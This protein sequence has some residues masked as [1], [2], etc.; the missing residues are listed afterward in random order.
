M[1]STPSIPIQHVTAGK[2]NKTK[3]RKR[4][5]K[6]DKDIKIGNEEVKLSLFI[7]MITC[8][9]NP[10]EVTKKL[11]EKPIYKNQLYILA[12]NNLKFKNS[13][14]NSIKIMKYL[15]TFIP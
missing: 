13:I 12:T 8:V 7:D 14:Y 10:K 3:K 15:G 9:A 2:F 6:I 4:K 11:L 5:R 1:S